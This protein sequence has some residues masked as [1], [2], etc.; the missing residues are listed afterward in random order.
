MTPATS[1]GTWFLGLLCVVRN[2]FNIFD[3]FRFTVYSSVHVSLSEINAYLTPIKMCDSA[4][5]SMHTVIKP[6][7]FY[8]QNNPQGSIIATFLPPG[9]KRYDFCSS[10]KKFFPSFFLLWDRLIPHTSTSSQLSWQKQASHININDHI[11]KINIL[12]E[13]ADILPFFKAI[14]PAKKSRKF[15]PHCLES[16]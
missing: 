7:P 14:S 9:Q 11:S 1:F 12:S 10:K 2:S 8:V 6:L 16:C 13:G 5:L 15:P 4:W 3:W